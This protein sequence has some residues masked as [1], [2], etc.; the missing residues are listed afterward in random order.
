MATITPLVL[1]DCDVTLN[2]KDLIGHTNMVAIRPSKDV[3][4]F[5][6][7]GDDWAHQAAS[8]LRWDGA[9]RVGYDETASGGV[10]TL[11]T[12]YSTMSAVALQVDP[13]SDGTSSNW[14]FTGSVHITGMPIEIDRTGGVVTVEAPFT[15]TGTLAKGT[16]GT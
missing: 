16:V 13:K 14:R 3:A 9:I 1:K 10:D 7:F 6:A 2:T 4:E 8:I 5:A 11:W 15:G 12:C